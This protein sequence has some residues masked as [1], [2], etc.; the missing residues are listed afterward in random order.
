MRCHEATAFDLGDRGEIL[1]ALPGE[2]T[3]LSA[4]A[5]RKPQVELCPGNTMCAWKNTW[6]TGDKISMW[7]C[8]DYRIPRLEN[9]SWINEPFPV[10][11]H[12]VV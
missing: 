1:L 11:D 9:G 7:A 3:R 2:K 6:Y 5:P 4:I 8:Y 10:M 12:D